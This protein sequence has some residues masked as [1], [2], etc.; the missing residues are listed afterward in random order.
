MYWGVTPIILASPQTHVKTN[1]SQI[2]QKQRHVFV[3]ISQLKFYIHILSDG[4]AF[5]EG[6]KLFS[7]DLFFLDQ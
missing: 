5:K 6:F 1:T 7:S 4:V 2:C 3:H